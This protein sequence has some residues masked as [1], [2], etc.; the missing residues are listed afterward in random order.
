M[1]HHGKLKV[2]LSASIVMLLL[3]VALVTC[4]KKSSDTLVVYSP[5]KQTLVDLVVDMYQSDTGK[6]VEVITAGTGELIAR[7]KTEASNP[8]ADVFWG[9][10]MNTLIPETS[11]FEE[12]RSPNESNVEPAFKNVE[13]T[14][15]RFSAIPSTIVVNTTEL[16][17]A[18]G[19]DAQIT[20]YQSIIDLVK[21][22]PDLKGRVSNANPSKSSSSFEQLINQ[23][24][25]FAYINAEQALGRVAVMED[26][27]ST[28]LGAAWDNVA[29]LVE[30]YDGKH[31]AGSGAV[32]TDV[33][34]GETIVG[35]SYEMAAA[36][37]ADNSDDLILVYP[38]EGSVVKADGAAIIKGAKNLEGAKEFMDYLLSEKVQNVIKSVYRRAII[39]NADFSGSPLAPL[40]TFRVIEDNTELNDKAA[41]LAKYAEIFGN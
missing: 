7:V 27:T 41:F 17:K 34:Q 30:V 13:G 15:S 2:L 28:Y 20:G 24:W 26:I 25:A 5:H 14:V 12:Y 10:S 38:E 11:L 16:A 3:S 22:C 21:T 1:Y 4:T 40:N 33:V 9:G 37:A 31:S 32:I 8:N 18:C 29:Q 6:K 36:E 19:S 39:K 23:V 35:L